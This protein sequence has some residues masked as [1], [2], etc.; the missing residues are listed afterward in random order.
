MGGGQRMSVK[1]KLGAYVVLIALTVWFGVEFYS[2]FHAGGNPTAA[3]VHPHKKKAKHSETA[4]NTKTNPPATDTN[5]AA[6]STNAAGPSTNSADQSLTATNASTNAAAQAGAAD[7]NA[8]GPVSASSS[9]PSADDDTR[10]P[11]HEVIAGAPQGG[12]VKFLA[13]FVLSAVGLGLLV[14]YDF[15]HAVGG[16]AA[17]YLF[18]NVADGQRDPEYE[19]AEQ[20]WADGN[21]LQAIQMLRDYYKRNPRQVHA[22][23]RIAEIYEKDLRNHLAAALEYE[24]VLKKKL[25]DNRWA[26]AAI[27]LCNLYSRL[28][29]QDKTLALLRRV[30]DE[31]PRTA[32][33]RKAREKLGLPEP[34]D[35][36]APQPSAPAAEPGEEGQPF[37]VESEKGEWPGGP[38]EQGET[39]PPSAKETKSSSNLPPGFRP[40]K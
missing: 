26:W 39:P 14:A 19:K 11:D 3:A 34:E 31:Y 15:T 30:A 18:D 22:A 36:D 9:S 1:F 7:T 37:D 17:D 2:H 16:K 38:S 28:G 12:T 27:H 6:L 10:I 20:V 21:H 33:A 32:A 23:L 25:P 13:L 8:P 35:L 24:E 29:Q 5:I 4:A 40:K